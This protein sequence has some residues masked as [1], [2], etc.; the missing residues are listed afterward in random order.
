V[1]SPVPLRKRKVTYG[2][3]QP[4]DYFDSLDSTREGVPW[5]VTFKV[6]VSTTGLTPKKSLQNAF[7]LANPGKEAGEKQAPALSLAERLSSSGE[8]RQEPTP[9][10]L[11]SVSGSLTERDVFGKGLQAMCSRT[12]C[13]CTY[14]YIYMMHAAR[15]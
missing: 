8:A 12:T 15:I 6:P 2:R 3:F 4:S 9:I 5:K 14:M 7:F 10:A 11:V 1:G 13:T